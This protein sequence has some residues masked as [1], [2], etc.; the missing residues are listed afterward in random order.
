MNEFWLSLALSFV[1]PFVST[2]EISL[3]YAGDAMQHIAQIR[4]AKSVGDTYSYTEC[5]ED[6]KDYISSADYSVVNF[7]TTLGGKPFTGYPCFS[8]PTEFAKSL[9]EAGFD[10]FLNANNHTLDRQDKGLKRTNNILDSLSISHIGTYLNKQDR[11]DKVPFIKDINGFKISFLNYTYGTN[12]ISPKNVVVNYIDTIQIKK[13]IELSRTNG[14]EIISV[15]IHWGDEYKLL[16][17]NNQQKIANFLLNQ[18]VDLII[19]GHPHVIQPMEIRYSEKYNKDCLIVYSLGN[20][21]SDMKTTDTRGGV[22]VRVV[23]TKDALGKAKLK[24]ANYSLIFTLPSDGK[25]NYRVVPVEDVTSG[26][27]KIQ[28]DNFE[29]SAERIF[30]KHNI[31]VTRESA[32]LIRN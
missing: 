30:S 28:A 31:G 10:L 22:M 32:N 11:E 1:N 4:A 9:H 29:K 3:L 12:G 21:I 23:I 19:G 8:S 17:N 13:D 2:Q 16:P 5:F 24:S 18:G 25:S 6:I 15:Q 14:A 7:E 27:R 20:F 26:Y